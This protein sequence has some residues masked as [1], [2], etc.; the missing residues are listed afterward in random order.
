M[1]TI[2]RLLLLLWCLTASCAFAQNGQV[3]IKNGVL[4]SDLNADSH[5]ILNLNL[6][7]LGLTKASVGLSLVDNTADASKPVSTLQAA[8]IALKEPSITAGTTGQFWRGDK[9]WLTYGALALQGGATTL[10]E[11]S[12]IV[13]GTTGSSVIRAKASTFGSSGQATALRQANSA[14]IG[15]ILST[16]TLANTGA[17]E[18]ANS[19]KAVVYTTNAAPVIFGINSIERMRLNQG[20]MVGTTT[21]PGVGALSVAAS[22]LFGTYVRSTSFLGVGASPATELYWTNTASAGA[23]NFYQGDPSSVPTALAR[24]VAYG[25]TSGFANQL[26]LTND[27]A[28]GYIQ[29]AAKGGTDRMR[30]MQGLNIGG[31]SDPGTGSLRVTTNAEVGGVLSIIGN[32]F[33]VGDVA[34]ENNLVAT[35]SLK[36]GV[37][38]VQVVGPRNTGWTVGT[39]TAN[40]GAINYDTA[41]A[42]QLAARVKALEDMLR[43][44]GLID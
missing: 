36:I 34:T 16:V 28:N 12:S 33:A 10:P 18:F 15:N 40:K 35:L 9:T 43:T 41:T 11:L 37:L 17:L 39:G 2:P 13:G 6:S 19:A 25:T 1:K 5:T 3:P 22:G 4:Q 24:I 27:A 31:T 42:G 20:L 8:A 32:T 21:D 44:H 14:S 7:G 38:P 29:F 26:R 23:I 30:L